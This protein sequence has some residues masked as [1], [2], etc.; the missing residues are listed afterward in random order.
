MPHNVSLPRHRYVYVLPEFV[1]QDP[2]PSALIPAVWFGVSVSHGRGLLCHV[3]LQS[4]AIVVDLPFHALRWRSDATVSHRMQDIVAWDCY[5]ENAEIFEPPYLSGLRVFVLTVD[6]TLG[7]GLGELWFAI[8]HVGDGYSAEPAQHKHLWV[9]AHED[10][11]FR[12][13][14]QDRVL[15]EE[16]SFTEM[17]GVPRIKRQTQVWCAE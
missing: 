14:P 16:A 2:H 10:G 3:L 9:V 12:L 4:G 13:M 11:A 1:L 7:D 5:G 8:D 17:A 15:V 6:H